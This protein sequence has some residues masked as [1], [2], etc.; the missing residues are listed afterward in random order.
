ML[1]TPHDARF[2]PGTKTKNLELDSGQADE[3]NLGTILK[4]HAI[5]Q[6]SPIFSVAY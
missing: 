6:E 2:K 3:L 5:G 4:V 1:F